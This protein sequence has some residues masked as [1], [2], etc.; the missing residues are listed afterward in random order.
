MRLRVE[1]TTLFQT[2][3]LLTFAVYLLAMHPDVMERAR[4]EVL[5]IVGESETPTYEQIKQ[6]RYRTLS[7]TGGLKR[8]LMCS[9]I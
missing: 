8:R 6:M 4:A 9:L 5:N 1:L 3:S 7:P 2:A